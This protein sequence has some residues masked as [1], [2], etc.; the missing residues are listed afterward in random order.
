MY[1]HLKST[2]GDFNPGLNIIHVIT[3]DFPLNK[4]SNEIAE[5][6]ENLAESVKKPRHRNP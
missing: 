2:L 1:D 5:E 6:I 4:F 3:N